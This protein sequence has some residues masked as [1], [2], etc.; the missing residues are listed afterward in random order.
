[1]T[2]KADTTVKWFT[3]R[4]PN[5]PILNGLKG[6]LVALLDACLVDGYDPRT[7]DSVVVLGGVA[8]VNI[9]AGNPYEKHAVISVSGASATT[10][11]AE[12]RIDSAAAT[13]FT[14]ICPGVADGNITG[15][16]LKRAP[17]GWE[18]VH[19]ATN[20]AVYRSSNLA[21]T[22]FLLFVDDD[23]TESKWA[24]V[25]G[26]EGMV[27][28][29]TT[30]ATNLFGGSIGWQKSSL[31]SLVAR[32]WVLTADDRFVG[33]TPA[34]YDGRPDSHTPFKFGDFPAANP[35]DIFNCMITGVLA[36]TNNPGSESSC[37]NADLIYTRGNRHVAG[38]VSGAQRNVQIGYANS[39][40]GGR[41]GSVASADGATVQFT[42]MLIADPDFRGAIP[43]QFFGIQSAPGLAEYTVVEIAGRPYLHVPVSANDT[44]PPTNRHM[45]F[46]IGGPWR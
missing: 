5:G 33:Y 2:T 41:V 21:A 6:S 42:N 18:K 9:S 20:K 46:D 39:L 24:R 13:S 14:F 11:N 34:F 15:V 29:T 37:T 23:Q 12:W 3:D 22:Q 30:G 45:L 4:N 28:A 17:A 7:P 8:T 27:G 10:L 43:G 25:Y 44:V 26:A 36:A 35:S 31:A 19:S 38:T 32:P 16:S 40:F 1:M